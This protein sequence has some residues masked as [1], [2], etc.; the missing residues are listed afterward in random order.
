MLRPCNSVQS[1]WPVTSHGNI[2][3]QG[4]RA[5][6]FRES[7]QRTFG[8]AFSVEVVSVVFK[9]LGIFQQARSPQHQP[10]HGQQFHF[11]VMGG[12]FTTSL[13]STVSSGHR[14]SLYPF[15]SV[16]SHLISCLFSPKQIFIVLSL[17]YDSS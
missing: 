1:S 15:T 2:V 14:Y 7:L 10:M 9:A 5:T 11:R 8:T 6:N 13:S 16:I 4:Y 3:L 12:M 17:S